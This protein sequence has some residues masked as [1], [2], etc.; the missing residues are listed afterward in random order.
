[1]TMIAGNNS[2]PVFLATD[3]DGTLIPLAGAADHQASLTLLADLLKRHEMSLAFV[4]G[5][6]F[7]SVQNAIKE[8]DLPLPNW[9]LCDVGTSAYERSADGEFHHVDRYAQTLHEIAGGVE[10]EPLLNLAASISNLR[11]QEPEKQSQFKTSFF[12]SPERLDEVVS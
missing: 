8:F 9:I 5:R 7:A 4:T 12:V 2:R 1:M 10:K 11:L 6:H 3:L